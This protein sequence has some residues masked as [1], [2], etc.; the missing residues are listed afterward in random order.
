MCVH[1]GKRINL[2]YN[3]FA[4]FIKLKISVRALTHQKKECC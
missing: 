1:D 3:L 2:F 4:K